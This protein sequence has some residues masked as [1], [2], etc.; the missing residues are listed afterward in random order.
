MV[1][2]QH[3]VPVRPDLKDLVEKL[4]FARSNDC[5]AEAIIANMRELAAEALSLETQYQH[6]HEV[7]LKLAEI[8]SS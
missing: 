7:L 2:Y 8:Q 6:V 4:E 1:P 5:W 3:F